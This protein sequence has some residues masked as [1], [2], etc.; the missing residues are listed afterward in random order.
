LIQNNKNYDF[1]KHCIV[2]QLYVEN[3]WDHVALFCRV[4]GGVNGA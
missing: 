1:I 4:A 2:F 3:E